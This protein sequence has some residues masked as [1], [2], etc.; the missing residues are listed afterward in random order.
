[1]D[2]GLPEGI[3]CIDDIIRKSKDY[4]ER[5]ELLTIYTQNR[6]SNTLYVIDDAISTWE[7]AGK[8]E[9]LKD[10]VE[11]LSAFH[12]EF[13]RWEKDSLKSRRSRSTDKKVENL[14]RFIELCER[15]D[16]KFAYLGG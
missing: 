2:S 8:P 9:H 13:S 1:M 6:V 3:T 14:Q 7:A 4:D 15:F 12:K 11:V 16:K 5:V 10:D